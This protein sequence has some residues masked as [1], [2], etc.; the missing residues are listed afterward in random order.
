MGLSVLV[1][2]G[3]DVLKIIVAWGDYAEPAGASRS[4]TSPICCTFCGIPD[5]RRTRR[6][7]IALSVEKKALFYQRAVV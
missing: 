5:G 4:I 7:N 2:S 3:V 1:P 6:Y